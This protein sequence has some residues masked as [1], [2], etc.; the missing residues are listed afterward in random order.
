MST[1]TTH[2]E[3]GVLVH[4]RKT[5]TYS[6]EGK[7]FV[8]AKEGTQYHLH[9]RNPHQHRVKV[10]LSVDGIN[11]VSGEPA[12][13]EPEETGYILDAG[14]SQ[15]F[16][17]Y[18]LD[19]ASVAAFKFTKAE[20]GYAQ[21]EKSLKGTTGVIGC[22]VWKEKVPVMSN[23][24]KEIHHHHTHWRDRWDWSD[25]PWW[26]DGSTITC[27]GPLRTFGAASSTATTLQGTLTNS[28][29]SMTFACSNSAGSFQGASAQG[30][31]SAMAMNACSAAPQAEVVQS[32][33]DANPFN[34]GSTFG[35]KVESRVKSVAFVVD[36]CVGETSIYYAFRAGLAALGIDLTKSAKVVF[37]AAFS[38]RYATPP[39]GWVG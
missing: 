4:G 26:Y 33:L 2:V 9:V 27:G 38:G 31:Q 25:R 6:H 15:T 18:R 14:E 24:V 34:A 28:T 17:G 21:A 19:D 20:G 32:C 16:K 12:T 39:R 3:L 35:E 10:V 23:T 1:H 30:M 5:D 37:P 22:K 11:I 13:G 29:N 36:T 8:E 7:T